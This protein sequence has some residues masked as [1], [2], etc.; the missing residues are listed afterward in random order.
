MQEIPRV[1]EEEHPKFSV[2]FAN[3]KE[4]SSNIFS[5]YIQY[6]KEN[7]IVRF[8]V[9]SFSTNYLHQLYNGYDVMKEYYYECNADMFF[10]TFGELIAKR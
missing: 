6:W 4:S 5:C 7:N 2:W 3:M 9:G 10:D 1:R 8:Y